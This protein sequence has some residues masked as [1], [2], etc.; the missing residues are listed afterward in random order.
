MPIKPENAGDYPLDP[1]LKW[2]GGKRWLL[3]TLLGLW[4]PHSSR[5]LVEPFC[6]GLSVSFGLMPRRGLLNDINPHLM[7]LYRQVADGMGAGF[8]LYGNTEEQYYIQRAR[9]NAYA[10][11]GRGATPSSAAGLFLYLNQHGYNGLC[12]FN[13]RGGFNVPYGK[14]KKVTTVTNWMPYQEALSRWTLTCGHYSSVSLD[15]SD[16]VY[17]DPPYD[18]TFADYSAGGFTWDDQ[19]A[20]VGWLAQHDGPVVLSNMGTERVVQL[21]VDSGF[22]VHSL[23]GRRSISCTGDRTPADEVIATRN[24]GRSTDAH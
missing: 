24:I 21:Y 8:G 18:G 14:R 19:V 10:K 22:A 5:R 20:L 4:M 7:N 15:P 6:G 11:T 13:R 23:K 9:F 17:C 12:R 2:A 1:F 3:P 16:F